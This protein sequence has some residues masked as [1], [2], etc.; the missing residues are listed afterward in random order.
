MAEKHNRH[1]YL[2]SVTN[3]R[4]IGGYKAR[5]GKTI[6]WR[7]IFRSGELVRLTREDFQIIKEEIRPVS[8]LDLRSTFEVERHG[9]GL[10]TEANV[11]YYNV[12]FVADGG[13]REANERRYRKFTN[14]GEFYLDLVQDKEFGQCIIEALEVIAEPKNHPLVF[15]CAVGKDRTGI[16]AAV[17]LSVLGVEDKD[18]IEDYS[19]SGP[20]MEKLLKN[21]NN[22]PGLA[23]AAKALPGYFWEATPDS[24]ALFLAEIRREYGSVEDYLKAQGV[25]PSLT[26][27]L[28]MALLT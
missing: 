19:L 8:L 3:L 14:M 27:R 15:H 25:E 20:Y 7:R 22:D 11:K 10:I 26:H 13:D 5:N 9:I 6:V 18:I 1:I 16:L 2:K 24:M 23:E 28:E 21:V 12:S 17:L 4:D